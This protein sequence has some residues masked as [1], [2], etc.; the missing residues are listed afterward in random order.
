MDHHKNPHHV[1]LNISPSGV[2]YHAFTSTPHY[3]SV[4]QILASLIPKVWLG[5]KILTRSTA[6]AVWPLDVLCQFKACQL[7][8]SVLRSGCQTSRWSGRS[9]SVRSCPFSF[10]Y[11]VYIWGC[12]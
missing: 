4:D 9:Y 6:T 12:I 2:I 3:Q 11:L 1:M 10:W 5:Y 8:L 7:L